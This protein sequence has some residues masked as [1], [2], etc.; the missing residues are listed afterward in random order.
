MKRLGETE[1][2]FSS[3]LNEVA[4]NEE[5]TALS[6]ERMTPTGFSAPKVLRPDRC[7]VTSGEDLPRR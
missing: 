4:R 5:K 3:R 2:R 7:T 1:A 6:P